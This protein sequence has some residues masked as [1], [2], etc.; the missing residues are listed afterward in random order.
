M[1]NIYGN[2]STCSILQT[3][4]KG[5]LSEYSEVHSFLD[6]FY[7]SRVGIRMLIG[8]QLAL[9]QTQPDGYVGVICNKVSPKEE[10]DRAIADATYVCERTYGVAPDVKIQVRSVLVRRII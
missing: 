6:K 4:G 8:Q 9:G 10:A 3:I 5:D 2:I 7:M 1:C